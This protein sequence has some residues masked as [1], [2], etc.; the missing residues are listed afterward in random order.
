M[1]SA[2]SALPE[3]AVWTTLVNWPL[4]RAPS[5]IGRPLV[6]HSVMPPPY[7]NTFSFGMRMLSRSVIAACSLSSQSPPLQ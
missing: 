3:A 4:L 1:A 7:T 5:S 2:P 6:V